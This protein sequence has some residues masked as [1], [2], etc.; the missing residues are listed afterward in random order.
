MPEF[1]FKA[2]D[3]KV[4]VIRGPEGATPQQAFAVLQQHL[5]GG[6]DAARKAEED[7]LRTEQ[8]EAL[9]RASDP[10]GLGGIGDEDVTPREGGSGISLGEAVTS[11]PFYAGLGEKF[12]RLKRGIQQIFSTKEEAERYT[13]LTAAEA[14]DI[15]RRLDAN[16]KEKAAYLLGRGTGSVAEMAV[17]TR[18]IPGPAKLGIGGPG[19]LPAAGRIAYNT[20]VG[21]GVSAADVSEP[22][23]SKTD[24]A[25]TGAAFGL[26]FGTAAETVSA[27]ARPLA[28]LF[29]T[30]EQ[31]AASG[32][33]LAENPV[34]AD[35]L[36]LTQQTG[37]KMTPGQLTGSLA[38]SEMRPPKG[39]NEAQ[40]KQTLRYFVTL[41]DKLSTHPA[42]PAKLAQKFGE[43]TDDM[44]NQMVETRKRVSDFQF[45]KFRKSVREVLVD[46]LVKKI[47]EIADNAVPGTPE[48]TVL[49]LQKKLDAQVEQS[50]G[51]LTTEQ[52]L[53]WRE[54]FETMLRGK[55]DLFAGLNKA[56]QKRLGAQLMESVNESLILTGDTLA[57]RGHL[58]PANLLKQAVA[59]HRKFSAPLNEL[60]NSA[61]GA[62]FRAKKVGPG[63]PAPKMTPEEAGRRLMELE[64][65]QVKAVYSIL[66]RRNPNLIQ[67]YQATRL[68]NAMKSSVAATPE[69]AVALAGQTRF[70]PKAAL[71]AL[72]D[73]DGLRAAFSSDPALLTRVRRGV[74]LLDRLSDRL[75]TGVGGSQAGASRAAEAARN[76]VSG[77]PIFLAGSA[78]KWLGPVG[79][80]KLTTTQGGLATLRALATAPLKSPKFTAAVTDLVENLDDDASQ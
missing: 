79:L 6:D 31:A 18:Y 7:A 1:K 59:S 71:K 80:W 70:D 21:A 75:K 3:G 28:R 57:K 40:A 17:L 32:G 34:L 19:V 43:A 8:Q 23:Q 16:P 77:S 49:S 78:A 67:Q 76:I 35:G 54:R 65:T 39:F 69:R 2:P 45:E 4:H 38:L 47:G 60:E 48:G 58:A 22:G 73:Q 62:I 9:D 52:L 15:K 64:P 72:G 27:A 63:A 50:G 53:V 42:P 36:G 12:V 66:E 37:V 20:G 11:Q 74:A 25:L 26:G 30:K 51:S 33:L 13:Q 55:S 29:T 10:L 5:G 61:L 56:S 24:Q 44:Y 41:R 14:A 46:P 68:H